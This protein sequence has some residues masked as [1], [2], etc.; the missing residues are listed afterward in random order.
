ME[1]NIYMCHVCE[2]V[3][4]LKFKDGKTLA[5]ARCQGTGKY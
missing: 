5:C 2:G 4:I 3:G 1:N